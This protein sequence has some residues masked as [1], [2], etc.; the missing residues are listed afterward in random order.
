MPPLFRRLGASC[1][2]LV[3]DRSGNFAVLFAVLTIPFTGLLGV[4]VDIMRAYELR[5]RLDQAADAAAL[6]AVSPTSRAYVS[7]TG[8]QG[9]DW[10]EEAESFFTGVKS[11]LAPALAV[12]VEADVVRDGVTLTSTVSYSTVLPTT[13]AQVLGIPSLTVRGQARAQVKAGEYANLHVLVDNS[14]SM[15]VGATQADVDLMQAQMPDKCAFACH[16]MSG[17]QN[18]YPYAAQIGARLRIDVVS[19]A[20]QRMV[21]AVP[22]AD[23]Q[24]GRYKLSLYSL[25]ASAE[26]TQASPLKQVQPLTTD[27]DDFRAAAE[28][29]QLMSVPYMNFNSN[30]DSNIKQALT[31][32]NDQVPLAGDGTGATSAKQMILLISDGMTNFFSTAAGCYGRR[33]GSICVAYLDTSIC[34]TVKARGV[35]IAVLYTTYVPVPENTLFKFYSSRSMAASSPPCAPAPRRVFMRRRAPLRRWMRCWNHCSARW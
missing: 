13:F 33:V 32:L 29:V 19:D 14:P 22:A 25:G 11:R 4:S 20:L 3:R 16:D 12:E 24:S 23:L 7:N 28:S 15:G 1:R 5:S 10:D 35:K 26:E 34:D 30:I 6:A 31:L 18:N 17:S 8:S 21:S 27:M 9:T 2:S